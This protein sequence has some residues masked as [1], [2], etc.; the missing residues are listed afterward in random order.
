ML[1]AALGWRA[2]FFIN[3]PIGLFALWLTL[4][5]ARE[6]PRAAGRGIDLPG[7]AAAVLALAMLA[8]ATIEGGRAGWTAPEVLIP[9]ALAALALAAFISTEARTPRPMLPL[10]LFRDRRFG[11]R[12]VLVSGALLAALACAAL[13]NVDRD[14]SYAA[15]VAQL[16]ALGAA[17]GLIVPLMTS[18]LL[19]SV[20][21]WVT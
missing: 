1:I 11:A 8:A 14:T 12:R 5:S 21:R 15:M 7:Q 13:L 18:E 2:V 9:Y 20:D 16:V 6:T 19:A 4:R 3:V 10:T 17:V